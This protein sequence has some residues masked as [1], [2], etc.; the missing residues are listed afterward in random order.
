MAWVT[1]NFIASAPHTQDKTGSL[2]TPSHS[3]K[4]EGGEEGNNAASCGGINARGGD[5][6]GVEGKL[7]SISVNCSFHGDVQGMEFNRSFKKLSGS[8]ISDRR[9]AASRNSAKV[10]TGMNSSWKVFRA[11]SAAS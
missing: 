6:R 11:L 4:N 7:A 1:D 2:K 5:N 10:S 8:V 3:K 9:P